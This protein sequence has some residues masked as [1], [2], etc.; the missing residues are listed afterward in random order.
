[1][2]TD[3]AQSDSTKPVRGGLTS[4]EKEIILLIANGDRVSAIAERLCVQSSTVK[5]HIK[6]I[7]VKTGSRTQAQAVARFLEIS[8]GAVC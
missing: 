7:L 1:V 6:S 8:K 2:R 5:F 4:R 3:D